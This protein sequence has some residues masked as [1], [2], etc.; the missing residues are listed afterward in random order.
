MRQIRVVEVGVL[1]QWTLPLLSARF[2][3]VI[4][5]ISGKMVNITVECKPDSVPTLEIRTTQRGM[6]SR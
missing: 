2:S 6:P 4:M 1:K 5:E 3:S